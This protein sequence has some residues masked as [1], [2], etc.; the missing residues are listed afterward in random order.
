MSI[1]AK[2]VIISGL[3]GAGK[4]TALRILEDRGFYV[5]DNLPPVML[6][7]LLDTLSSNNAAETWGVAAV[8]DA[9]GEKVIGELEKSFESI[10]S[11]GV[12]TELV[13]LE[14]ADE[15]LV[16]RYEE[17]RRRHPLGEGVTIIEGITRERAE[18]SALKKKA[19]IVIDTSDFNVSDFRSSLMAQ[20]GMNEYPFTVIVSSFGFKNG[21]PRDCD[22]MFDTR[23]L[24]NPNYVY[25]LKPLSGRDIEVQKYLDRIPEKQVFMKHLVSFMEFILKHYE[26]TGKKQLHV[27][28]GC[29]GGR[30]RSV[31]VAEQLSKIIS[32]T[33][34]RTA[35]NH[36]DIDMEDR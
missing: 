29:T 4:S 9:R 13:F 14:A 6:P 12:K 8:V 32:D 34:L 20:L 26:N 17:T 11:T 10:E 36:R 3:S 15:A 2:C 24:P 28:V 35:I 25:E 1:A 30:H 27:A 19:S 33:G 5:V 7:S 31:A 21:I 22:Y 23:F 16:R 18:L